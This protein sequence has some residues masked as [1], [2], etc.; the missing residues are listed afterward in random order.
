M[1]PGPGSTSWRAPGFWPAGARAIA[2]LRGLEELDLAD[3]PIGDEGLVA[4]TAPLATVERLNLADCDLGPAGLAALLAADPPAL[5][6]LWL[7]GNR[8][9][10]DAVRALVA[11]PLF[12][13]LTALSL[14]H[15]PTGPGAEAALADHPL[16]A[17][18]TGTTRLGDRFPI[19]A[20]RWPA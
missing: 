11:S 3:N 9:D 13:R 4:L 19:H 8:L 16:A 12:P 15:N 10:D 14:F 18:L 5:R 6:E 2:R 7:H 17:A 20:S 1:S